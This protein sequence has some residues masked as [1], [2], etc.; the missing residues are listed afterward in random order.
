[1]PFPP[2]R[3][4][5]MFSLMRI[6]DKAVKEA[7]PHGEL[8]GSLVSLTNLLPL[9]YTCVTF[10]GLAALILTVEVLRMLDFRFIIWKLLRILYMLTVNRFVFIIS[11]CWVDGL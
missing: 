2:L 10:I 6:V 5:Y 8:E 3:K 9:I 1:L 7:M 4:E 11:K